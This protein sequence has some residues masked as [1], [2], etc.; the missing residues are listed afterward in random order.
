MLPFQTENGKMEAQA[1][2][3]NQ[4]TVCSSCKQ[5]LVVR[6]FVDEETNGS[7]PFA[8]RLIRLAHLCTHYV[9]I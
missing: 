8:N 6:P 5:K 4:F 7:Y 2:F 1:I 3:Q 9:H